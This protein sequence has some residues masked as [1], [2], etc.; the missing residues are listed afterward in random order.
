MTIAILIPTLIPI[1]IGIAIIRARVPLTDPTA[2]AL[3]ATVV[4]SGIVAIRDAPAQPIVLPYEAREL[5]RRDLEIYEPMFAMYLDI[6]KGKILEELPAEEVK[7][8][9]KSFVRKWNH[10]ELAEGWYDPVTLEKAR[11]SAAEYAYE[12]I[13]RGSPQYEHQDSAVAAD[14]TDGAAAKEDE[15]DENM[16][17]RYQSRD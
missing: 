4:T 7:G 5:S 17:R 14:N 2:I 9:W 3:I 8:R 10:G 15:E 16:D 13:E 1:D 11:Q 6:Q 12:P